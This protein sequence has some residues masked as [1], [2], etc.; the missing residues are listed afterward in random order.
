M[1]QKIVGRAR[2]T[3]YHAFSEGNFLDEGN[4]ADVN[5]IGG[6]SFYT[7]VVNEV[8]WRC[9]MNFSSSGAPT[10]SLDLERAMLCCELD[11]SFFSRDD[12]PPILEVRRITNAWDEDFACWNNRNNGVA[13]DA[14]GGD[15]DT[16]TLEGVQVF[17]DHIPLSCEIT[18]MVKDW[19][20]DSQWA[21][22]CILKLADEAIGTGNTNEVRGDGLPQVVLTHLDYASYTVD[23]NV[24]LPEPLDT[25]H[26]LRQSLLRGVLGGIK[27]VQYKFKGWTA[28]F[29]WTGLASTD[30]DNLLKY[31]GTGP[32]SYFPDTT[33]YPKWNRRCVMIQDAGERQTSGGVYGFDFILA[34]IE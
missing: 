5:S 15:Y 11:A 25:T 3:S 13:W 19:I 23:G 24:G 27:G 21:Y 1:G 18:D 30:R 26:N 31:V 28:R 14:A 20:D 22:G 9:N 7:K 17:K 12:P 10:D 34:E 8:A 29:N 32:I 4:P 6:N 2:T 33:N 16:A